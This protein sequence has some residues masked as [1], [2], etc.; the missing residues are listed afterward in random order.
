[1]IVIASIKFLIDLFF[2]ESSKNETAARIVTVAVVACLLIGIV[3]AG[4]CAYVRHRTNQTAEA[5]GEL[6]TAAAEAASN[7][8]VLNE[9]KKELENERNDLQKQSVSAN[10]DARNE[11]STDS[12]RRSGDFSA[13]R[14]EWCKT[15]R[16]DSKCRD[17]R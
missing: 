14:A 5:V 2:G 8:R 12:S 1:M 7:A 9:E 17:L 3:A 4:K 15:H 13:V 6:K 11:F 10:A 16:T